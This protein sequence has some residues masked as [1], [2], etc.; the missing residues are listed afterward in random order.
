MVQN[1]K[2][3]PETGAG[4]WLPIPASGDFSLTLRMYA[5]HPSV[6]DFS[7]QPPAV[8]PVN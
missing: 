1:A 5:P 2:P 4:N 6:I 7:W 8:T 3:G